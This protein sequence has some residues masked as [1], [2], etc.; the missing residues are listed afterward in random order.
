MR[1]TNSTTI[2]S[3]A[4]TFTTIPTTTATSLNIAEKVYFLDTQYRM[5]RRICDFVNNKIY[6][7]KLR[8]EAAIETEVNL[9]PVMVYDICNGM[10]KPTP[11]GSYCNPAKAGFIVNLFSKLRN[12]NLKLKILIIT[13]YSGRKRLIE[14]K[15]ILQ[16][17]NVVSTVD[18]AQG[19]EADIVISTKRK[20]LG[21]LT[22]K[23]KGWKGYT[24]G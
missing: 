16:D 24:P 3:S 5:D 21:P 13:G 12:Q 2:L 9:K 17:P 23:W 20:L 11:E 14:S 19:K 1:K 8:T 6:E 7:G 22:S 4:A 15:L 10:E 18:A